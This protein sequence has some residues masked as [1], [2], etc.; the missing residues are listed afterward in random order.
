MKKIALLIT[1]LFVHMVALASENQLLVAKANKAYTDGLYTNAADLYKKVISSGYESWEL[2]YNLGNSYYKLT[3]YPSAI[4]YYEKAR[5]LNPGNEDIDFNL[6]VTN[7]K[8]SDKIEPLPELFYKKWFRN[9]VELLS[10]DQWAWIVILTFILSL[11]SSLFYF[12][13]QR[14]FLRKSGFWLGII[15]FL[16]SLT[17]FRFAW[18]NYGTLKSNSAAIIFTPTVT[19]KSSPDDKS[20]D[21]FVLHEGTKVQ[22]LDNIGTWYE[23]KISSGSVGWLPSSAVEKI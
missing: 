8:I 16:L 5:K 3:D 6:K 20:I 22:I 9:F 10:V 4:L 23:I 19:I 18:E 11:T 13:S 7:N 21:L 15:L 2:Y 17:S 14:V 1:V 12:I